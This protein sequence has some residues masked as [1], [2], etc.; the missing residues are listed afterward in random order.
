[1]LLDFLEK[2][3]RWEAAFKTNCRYS[4]CRDLFIRFNISFLFFFLWG[5]IKTLIKSN[6]KSGFL[7]RR[8]PGQYWAE[9]R[10]EQPKL[11]YLTPKIP[12]L[13]VSGMDLL[14][15]SSLFEGTLYAANLQLNFP[16]VLF[17]QQ[18]PPKMR[19]GKHLHSDENGDLL[20]LTCSSGINLMMKDTQRNKTKIKQANI[21]GVFV[22]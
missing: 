16:I 13:G 18:F 9:R 15:H 21:R 3:K 6:R 19:R 10:W 17:L 4:L 20:F 2:T 7:I 14:S 12:Q 1:M 11:S 22:T 5:I 8:V